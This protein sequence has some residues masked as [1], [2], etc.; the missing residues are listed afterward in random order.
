MIQVDQLND[1]ERRDHEGWM[2]EALLEARKAAQL[3]EVPIGA[4][5]VRD[6]QI[7]GRGHNVREMAH[8]ATGHAEIQAIQA[9]NQALG[10]WRLEGARLYVTLEPCPMCAGAV[11]MARLDQVIYAAPDPKGGCA[12]SLMN[13]LAE[14]RFNHQPQVIQGVLAQESGRLMRDFF[15]GLRQRNKARRQAKPEDLSTGGCQ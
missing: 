6:Q 2:R 3:G 10:A 15:Q 14:D 1:E 11:I 13:L 9:A 5:V 7:I 8:L 4:V 12:G